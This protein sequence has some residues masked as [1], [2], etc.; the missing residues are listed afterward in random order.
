MGRLDGQPVILQE[1]MRMKNEMMKKP[2]VLRVEQAC[3]YYTKKEK[4]VREDGT[5]TRK[6]IVKAVDDVSFDWKQ[7]RYWV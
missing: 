2:S 7:E 1:E 3:R 5:I 6:S 4:R